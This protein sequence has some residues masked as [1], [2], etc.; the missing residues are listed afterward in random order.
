M[1]IKLPTGWG[2]ATILV[3]AYALAAIVGGFVELVQGDLDYLGYMDSLKYAAGASGLLAIGRGYAYG[4]PGTGFDN[5][6]GVEAK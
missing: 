4:G 2:P 5:E 6:K 1:T 3:V